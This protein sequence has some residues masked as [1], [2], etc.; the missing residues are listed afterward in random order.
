MAEPQPAQD[1]LLSAIL[2][3]KQLLEHVP[4]NSAE[5]AELQTKVSYLYGNGKEGAV[6]T[7]QKSDS[8]QNKMLW[9]AYGILLAILTLLGWFVPAAIS[10]WW[11]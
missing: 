10:H 8:T 1:P 5:L 6:T 2:E 9:I 11:K 4:G 3:L 7:L